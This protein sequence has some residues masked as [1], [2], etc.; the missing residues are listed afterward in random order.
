MHICCLKY[1]IKAT[2]DTLSELHQ[3]VANNARTELWR[4]AHSVQSACM[5]ATSTYLWH[6]GV[7]SF[8][9][10]HQRGPIPLRTPF[11]G[12][13]LIFRSFTDDIHLFSLL[14]THFFN[15]IRFLN[16]LN[17]VKFQLIILKTN[18]INVMSLKQYLPCR[19]LHDVLSVS[20][21]SHRKGRK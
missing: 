18:N 20:D 21:K 4:Q 1:Q 9:E 13:L 12:S 6:P 10:R 7:Y 3:R 2:T 19:T 17:I 8:S 14:E 5:Q 11:S 16:Q 15:F